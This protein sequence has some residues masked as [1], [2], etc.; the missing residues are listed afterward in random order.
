MTHSTPP[1]SPP[2]GTAALGGRLRSARQARGESVRGLARKIGCSASLLSQIELGKSAP[3]VGVLYNLANE[4]GVSTDFLLRREPDSRGPADNGRPPPAGSPDVT[5]PTPAP[6]APSPDGF[7]SL[8]TLP[9]SYRVQVQR[10]ADRQAVD[11]GGG[12]RWERLT[13]TSQTLVDFLEIV[14]QP[15][16]S[17]DT[18]DHPA[19][20]EGYEYGVVTE[21][22]LTVRV[23]EEEYLLG[24][25]DS[26]AFDSTVPHAFR[27]AGAVTARA[28]WF[29]LHGTPGLPTGP[30]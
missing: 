18:D 24:A 15:G 5:G 8:R 1:P 22:E 14:Y 2:S 12:V 20:H 29:V 13:T 17:S 4:L 28:V 26:V 6:G 9:P 27:N 23:G 25:G 3:S 7:R 11:F 30:S 21:G 19:G 16:G 10:A